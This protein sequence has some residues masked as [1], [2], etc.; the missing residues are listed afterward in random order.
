[1]RDSQRQAVYDWGEKVRKL[2]PKCK[3]NLGPDGA[4]CL[5]RHICLKEGKSPLSVCTKARGSRNT[6]NY[7][8]RDLIIVLPEWAQTPWCVCHEVAH[9][10]NGVK[11]GWHGPQFTTILIRLWETYASI[12]AVNAKR[13]GVEQRPRRVRFST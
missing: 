11:G 9:Y 2:H 6:A 5:V 10:L 1:M 7:S 12:P 8:P 4:A 13:L 3:V